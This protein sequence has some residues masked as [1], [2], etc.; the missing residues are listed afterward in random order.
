MLGTTFSMVLQSSV[1]CFQALVVNLIIWWLQLT[2][3]GISFVHHILYSSSWP[4]ISV[5]VTTDWLVLTNKKKKQVDR[6]KSI[7]PCYPSLSYSFRILILSIP[8][9]VGCHLSHCA[10]CMVSRFLACWF[11]VATHHGTEWGGE[12]GRH[13][14]LLKSLKRHCPFYTV[15]GFAFAFCSFFFLPCWPVYCALL[16]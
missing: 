13:S 14:C 15:V 12:K 11:P 10:L 7:L 5:L 1:T 9:T 3:A 16:L 2:S 8:A 6:K 4:G